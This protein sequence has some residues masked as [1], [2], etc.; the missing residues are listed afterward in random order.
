VQAVAVLYDGLVQ[1]APTLGAMVAHAVARSRV[2]GA[3]GGLALL[4]AIEPAE[5]KRTYQ[6]Y[7]SARAHLLGQLGRHRDACHDYDRAIGLSEAPEVRRFLAD[8]KRA[9]DPAR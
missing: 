2:D 9:I 8:K 6:P 5:S 3:E 4:E 1:L 7:W